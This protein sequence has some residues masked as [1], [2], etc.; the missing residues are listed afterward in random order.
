[1]SACSNQAHT[2][3]LPFFDKQIKK[4]LYKHINNAAFSAAEDGNY[5]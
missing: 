1:M 2:F 3:L 4:V 5:F